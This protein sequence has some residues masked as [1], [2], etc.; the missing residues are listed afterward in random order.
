ML[1]I[2]FIEKNVTID[3]KIELIDY[4]QLR[5]KVPIQTNLSPVGMEM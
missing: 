2:V 5:V 3:L 1:L 4:A